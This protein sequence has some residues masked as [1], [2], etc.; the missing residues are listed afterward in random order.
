MAKQS[1]GAA[2]FNK[3]ATRDGQPM[4]RMGG[5]TGRG[6]TATDT[7]N[8]KGAVPSSRADSNAGAKIG[9]G[10]ARQAEG[11]STALFRPSALG[12]PTGKGLG[13]RW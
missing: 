6:L 5:E 11:A 9:S 2:K 8:K 4:P 12:S 7:D 1:I 3:F 13:N 10:G